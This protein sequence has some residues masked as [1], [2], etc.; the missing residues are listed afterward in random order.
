MVALPAG[1]NLTV[2]LSI[3]IPLYR[4]SQTIGRLVANLETLAVAGG[5]EIVLVHDGSPDDTLAVC[6]GLLA[7][8]RVPL[9]LVDLARNFG[10]HNAI[11][12]GLR[13]AR[14]EYVVTMDDDLQN[15]PSEVLKLVQHARGHGLDCVFG[16][17]ESKQHALW[18]NLGSRLT[19]AVSRC[20][21]EKPAGLYLSSFRCLSRFLVDQIAR[22]DGPFPYVDGLILQTTSRLG[23]VA[24]AHAARA[25]GRSG[26]TLRKLARLWMSM[27]VNFSV[28]PLRLATFLGFGLG[29]FGVALL[30]VVLIEYLVYG[31]PARGWGS[32][33]GTMLVFSGAQMVILGLFGEYLGRVFLTLNRR[34]QSVVRSVER[35]GP[36]D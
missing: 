24:V 34:P 16:D 9:T 28:M 29:L 33:M 32:L 21:L 30:A 5:L 1:S 15:P 3:V 2:A 6:R 7:G 23:S 18:R 17:Y 19:N 26:Y 10:E 35:G 8:A 31:T 11:L 12:A 36:A 13:Q 25:S 22:Y 14:G 4:S 20:V 27:F